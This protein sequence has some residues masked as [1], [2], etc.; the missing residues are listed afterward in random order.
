MRPQCSLACAGSACHGRMT[1]HVP[2]RI[3]GRVPRADAGK[4]VWDETRRAGGLLR[5]SR[6]A[7]RAQTLARGLSRRHSTEVA[8]GHAGSLV[9]WSEKAPGRTGPWAA[10]PT[11]AGQGLDVSPA[12]FR[13]AR[14]AISL[15][16]L[17]SI[18]FPGR[19]FQKARVTVLVGDRFRAGLHPALRSHPIRLWSE[20]PSGTLS[21]NQPNSEPGC[22][23]CGSCLAFLKY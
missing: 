2:H 21:G 6:R 9:L 15:R 3:R 1:P 7:P 10:M 13:C 12:S 18:A 11:R 20:P 14:A 23:D 16:T 8:T 22:S 19:G 5:C 17:V 4:G